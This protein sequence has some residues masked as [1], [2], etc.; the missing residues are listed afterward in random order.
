MIGALS[1]GL[2]LSR[3]AD[4]PTALTEIPDSRIGTSATIEPQRRT[5]ADM[6]AAWLAAHPVIS[7]AEAFASGA[8]LGP[9]SG[10]GRDDN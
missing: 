8:E 3:Q 1:S 10:S 4:M 9:P 5:A 7:P 2:M 6:R